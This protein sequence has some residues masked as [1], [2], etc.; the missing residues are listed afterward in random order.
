M[1]DVVVFDMV[2]RTV[3]MAKTRVTA[4]DLGNQL[5]CKTKA[6]NQ[7]YNIPTIH[8]QG[9]YYFALVVLPRIS[10]RRLYRVDC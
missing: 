7:G 3:V 2:V 1:C 9:N 5:G 10:R 6:P 8:R 4:H